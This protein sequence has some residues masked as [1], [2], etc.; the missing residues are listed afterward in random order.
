MATIRSNLLTFSDFPYLYRLVLTCGSDAFA[1]GRP[2]YCSYPTLM[3]TIAG[4]LK[5]FGGIPYLHFAQGAR[6]NQRTIGRPCQGINHTSMSCGAGDFLAG[7]DVPYLYCLVKACRGDIL[8]IRRPGN[9][10][11]PS[12]MAAIDERSG[13]CGSI[14]YMHHTVMSSRGYM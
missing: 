12:S 14:P 4:N 2:G 10:C 9:R 7:F 13:S 8:S 3:T 1:V 11:Y 6:S 5:S